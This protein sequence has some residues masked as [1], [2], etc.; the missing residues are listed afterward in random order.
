MLGR[1]V[2]VAAVCIVALA[3]A[4]AHA[5]PDPVALRP[6]I[7]Q[8]VVMER[9]GDVRRVRSGF[10]VSEAGHVATVAR[11]VVGAA[12]IAIVPLDGATELPARIVHANERADVALLAADG[13]SQPALTLAKDGF[14]PGR[15]V[16]SAGVWGERS[17]TLFVADAADDVPVAMSEGAVG[18]H[19]EVSATSGQPAVSLVL[20]NAMIPA[21]G[22]GG[23]LLNECGEVAGANR[24]APDAPA[25]RRDEA[26]EAVVHGAAVSAIAG[27]MLPA[28]IAFTQSDASCVEALSLA[29]AEAD[30]AQA[31]AEKARA[32]AE[33]A[34]AEAAAAA[35]EAEAQA[36]EAKA[37]G[38][39]LE[40]RQQALQ[41]AEA[42]V[43]ELE[44]Q[45][46]D[47]TRTGAAE[48]DA[49]R[50]A[51]DG[52]RA[53]QEAAQTAV[54]AKQEE[55]EAL[56]LEREA[57]AQAN[58]TR[59]IVIV[60]L[61]AL[62]LAIIGVI[63]VVLLRRRA[64]ETERARQQAVRAE[65]AAAQA[66]REAAQAQQEAER[67]QA[68]A[69]APPPTAPDCL[70]TGEREDG[71]PVALKLPGTLLVGEGAV[72]GRSPRDAT[73]LIDDE[74]LSREHARV[75]YEPEA[76]LQIQDL[77]STNGTWVNGRRLQPHTP[78]PLAADDV[79]ELGGVKLR[80]VWEP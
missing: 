60:A 28:G 33:A 61:I 10:V 63:V 2:G 21:V 12:R 1:F 73:L 20:H 38:A 30:A 50:E 14:S 35:A 19:G 71:Q 79:V 44:T 18:Q 80:V 15:L 67:A 77:D 4:P 72:I 69:A 29:Q 55:L 31:E 11:G 39:A 58:R 37:Q 68:E 13:L 74:T 64:A 54:A 51:L 26:P 48:A 24:G 47:A 22:Y 41:E 76:G 53:E 52:A 7:V 70:L 23:P 34:R 66:E 5:Q 8:V 65:Q 59:F 75:S 40:A 42:R 45:Y 56:L 25:W 36:A 49:L 46:E 57:E 62:L 43:A 3:A 78:T 32:E 17:A 9:D 16:F 6:S 27:L